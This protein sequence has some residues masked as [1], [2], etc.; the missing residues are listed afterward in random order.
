MTADP[1][2]AGLVAA[3]RASGREGEAERLE[4]L[5]TVGASSSSLETW[6]EIGLVL[7]RVRPTLAPAEVDLRLR[8]ERGLEAVRRVWPGMR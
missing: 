8:V 5:V 4:W 2:F 7:Q 3:L 1:D 6:G